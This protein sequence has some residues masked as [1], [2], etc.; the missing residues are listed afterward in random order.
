MPLAASD[1]LAEAERSL[2]GHD[3]GL[4]GSCLGRDDRYPGD[5]D[6]PDCQ[7]CGGSGSVTPASNQ[8]RGKN[9]WPTSRTT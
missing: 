1:L 3:G 5:S 7:H 2:I 4:A 9:L 6:P 8:E